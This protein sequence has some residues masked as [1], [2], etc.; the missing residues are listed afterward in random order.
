[1]FFAIVLILSGCGRSSP[2]R[3]YI[4][5]GLHDVGKPQAA[6]GAGSP[7]AIGVGPVTIPDHLNRPQI[8]TRGGA[9]ELIVAASDRWGGSLQ[10]NV[11]RVIAENLSSLVPTD[12]VYVYPWM[13]NIPIDY[14]V[15]VEITRLDGALGGDVFLNARWVLTGKDLKEVIEKRSGQYSESAGGGGY[16]DFV[17]AQSRLLEQLSGDIAASLKNIPSR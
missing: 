7:I 1:L 10:E 11:A 14:S 4:L 16:A 3:Y 6:R 15:T 8:V 5:S 12:R 9:N 13:P 2:S 17:A